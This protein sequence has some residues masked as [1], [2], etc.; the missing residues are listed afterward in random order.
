MFY[1]YTTILLCMQHVRGL[2]ALCC[3]I[4][5]TWILRLQVSQSL[6]SAVLNDLFCH[7]QS[8]VRVCVCVCEG[9]AYRVCTADGSWWLNPGNRT[10]SNYTQCIN[11]DLLVVCHLIGLSDIAHTQLPSFIVCTYF[12]VLT[13]V[14]DRR[15]GRLLNDRTDKNALAYN[16][17]MHAQR[18]RSLDGVG[19]KYQFWLSRDIICVSCVFTLYQ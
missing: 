10:W 12:L 15:V 4:D 5:L 16:T 1:V 19:G 3:T 14:Q 18:D 7:S 13:F 8:A 11:T 17:H 6:R 9:K 2:Q